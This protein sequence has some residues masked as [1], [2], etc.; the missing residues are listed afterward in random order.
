MH[1][2]SFRYWR[3]SYHAKQTCV[4][5]IRRYIYEIIQKGSR[6]ADLNHRP[7]DVWDTVDISKWREYVANSVVYK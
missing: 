3:K 2:L 7:K 4:F 6:E 5:T 1:A